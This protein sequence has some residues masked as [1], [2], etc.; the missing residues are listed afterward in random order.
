MSRHSGK[1]APAYKSSAFKPVRPKGDDIIDL[2]ETKVESIDTTEEDAEIA[3]ETL[4]SFSTPKKKKTKKSLECSEELDEEML[5]SQTQ[6]QNSAE[7]GEEANEEDDE[8][9][10]REHVYEHA[11]QYGLVKTRALFAIEL[12]RAEKFIGKQPK[13][14]KQKV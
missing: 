12:K 7:G 10:F 9:D 4:Q 11:I 14:K 3:T 13:A 1:A 6:H 2:V 8:I 5:E